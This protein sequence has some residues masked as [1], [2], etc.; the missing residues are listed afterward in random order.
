VAE[1]DKRIQMMKVSPV[2]L[3]HMEVDKSI[4]ICVV[5]NNVGPVGSVTVKAT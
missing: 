5:I 2:R 1:D 4:D 3:D